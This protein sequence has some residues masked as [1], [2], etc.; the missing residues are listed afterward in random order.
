MFWNVC[1]DTGTTRRYVAPD[2]TELKHVYPKAGIA[3]L[4]QGSHSPTEPFSKYQPLVMDLVTGSHQTVDGF[5]GARLPWRRTKPSAWLTRVWLTQDERWMIIQPTEADASNEP[6]WFVYDLEKRLL[7]R[8]PPPE[9]RGAWRYQSDP[10]DAYVA[11]TISLHGGLV[12][13]GSCLL[14][15]DPRNSNPAAR[16]IIDAGA[17]ADVVDFQWI[18]DHEIVLCVRDEGH[19]LRSSTVP[20]GLK[21]RGVRSGVCLAD[22]DAM[23][24]RPVWPKEGL[25]LKVSIT[26]WPDWQRRNP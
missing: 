14:V 2:H 26:T 19:G 3:V 15:F 11:C 13:A 16:L 4:E 25:G 6:A 20:G 17:S 5:V 1:L 12:Y 21:F 23:S 18:S 22:I 7:Y 9:P 24:V 8:Q 10:G